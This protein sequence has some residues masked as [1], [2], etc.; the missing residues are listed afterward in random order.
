M[1]RALFLTLL[2]A[3]AL[4]L[5][6]GRPALARGPI[7]ILGN[8]DF[9]ADQ[10]VIGGTGTADDPYLI[11]AVD[12]QAGAEDVYAIRIENVTAAF[13]LRG[14]AIQGGS[15]SSGAA[16][17][18][19]NVAGGRLESCSV[20]GALNGLEI[21]SSTGIVLRDCVLYVSGIGLRVTGDVAEHYA[22]DI[23]ASNLLNNKEIRYYYGLDGETVSGL[24]AS[25]LTIAGS[26]N[27]KITGNTVTSGDGIRL[28]FVTGSTVSA[29]VVRRTS[30][31][32]TE[33]GLFLF[34]ASGNVVEGNWLSNNR[35]AGLQMTLSSQNVV[36]QNQIYANDSGIRLVAS[37]EN[38]ITGNLVSANV[39][40]ILLSGGSSGNT[41][42][43][44]VVSHEN[45]LQGITL[46]LADGNRIERNGVTDCEQ[47]ITLGEQATGNV[48]ESNTI[49]SGAYGISVYGS[50]NWIQ[51]NLIAQE[52]RG[53]LFPETYARSS[54]RENEIRGNVLTDNGQHLYLCLDS[55]GNRIVDNAF[56]GAA[57]ALVADRGTGN[58]WTVGG[59]GNYWGTTTVV[60]ANGDGVSDSPIT[61]YP[62]TAVDTAPRATWSAVGA[63][64]GILGTLTS[65]S[66]TIVNGAGESVQ[67]A[68]L[69]AD[70]GIEP[71][72]GFRGFP[73]A[74]IERFPGILFSYTSEA[75]RDFTMLTVLFDL[76]IAFFG[77][78]GSFVGGG[79][80]EA[81]SE[82]YEAPGAFQYAVE[83]AAGSL[84]RLGIGE[85]TRLVLP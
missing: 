54:A 69:L 65:S 37:D 4:A 51:K 62:S 41:L 11:A 82:I 48:V 31:V 73:A 42:T 43:E 3:G 28:A 14:V 44:N 35:L 26:R 8:G 57:S 72:A 70:A 64:L 53:I 50:Y 76:D 38:Q 55:S 75:E 29:N 66:I 34:H 6:V 83:L 85:G 80:M 24:T 15:S 33:H 45:T 32:Y 1:K 63:G 27:V 74:Y 59:A 22:H 67:Q 21:V 23:D 60:D 46:E 20:S 9:T 10:G 52:Q 81:E 19:A 49:L 77:A 13:T 17:R 18:I 78:D 5:V 47:G 40:G 30:P 39:S 25:H 12:V 68:V 7:T 58:V 71:W 2:T 16:V 61:V 36:R 56:L 84:E 79:T